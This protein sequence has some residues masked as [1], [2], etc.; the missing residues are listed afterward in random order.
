MHRDDRKASFTN[1]FDAYYP[2][3]RAVAYRIVRDEQIA[4]DVAQDVFTKAYVKLDTVRDTER[5][6]SWLYTMVK[7]KAIDWVRARQRQPEMSWMPQELS[8]PD[9]LEDA[10]IRREQ[11]QDA[12]LMLDAPF[13]RDFIWHEWRGYTAREIS[14][15][16]RE[17][18]NTVES[19]IRR[20]RGKLR[21]ILAAVDE[22]RIMVRV[23]KPLLVQSPH[24]ALPGHAAFEQHLASNSIL[25]VMLH[26]RRIAN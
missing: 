21:S 3:V 7:R 19:R 22:P 11:L 14:T 9:R 12:L 5:V 8:G 4:E 26:M 25:A 10:Y 17:S 1:L 18:I 24:I 13:R 15:M 20:A 6:R 2:M 23:A 16:T